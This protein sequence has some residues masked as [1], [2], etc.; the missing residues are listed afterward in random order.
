MKN[1][2]KRWRCDS[3]IRVVTFMSYDWS[4]L[5]GLIICDWFRLSPGCVLCILSTT[6]YT[7]AIRRIYTGRKQ[8]CFDERCFPQSVN[9][10][11][12]MFLNWTKIVLYVCHSDVCNTSQH[13]IAYSSPF[14]GFH[15][16]FIALHR[17]H[18][19]TAR[20]V[21]YHK[22]LRS[23]LEVTWKLLESYLKVTWKILE[24]RQKGQPQPE[25][26]LSTVNFKFFA[27]NLL[28]F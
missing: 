20:T 28:T 26:Q 15:R 6:R 14:I 18:Q 10:Q 27:P 11:L 22:L 9:G 16:L 24:R 8:R 25:C 2:E 12:Q 5:T 1:D 21:S 17:I 13:F 3:L 7:H 23:Y 4:E 19:M